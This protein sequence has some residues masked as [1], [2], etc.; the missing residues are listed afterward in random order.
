[1]NIAP[2]GQGVTHRG[3]PLY[4]HTDHEV[5]GATQG[6]PDQESSNYRDG[7]N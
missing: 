1:M 7:D 2:V 4:S 3:V 6:D 5:D